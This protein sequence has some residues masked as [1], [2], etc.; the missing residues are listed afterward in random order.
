MT[1]LDELLERIHPK[2]T[3]E[4]TSARADQALNAFPIDSP[5]IK[6]WAEFEAFMACFFCHVESAILHI[7]PARQMD[8]D[9]D[10]A[11]CAKFLEKQYGKEGRK[12]AFEMARTG[13]EGGLYAVLKKVALKIAEEYSENEIRARVHQFLAELSPDE[14]NA[15]AK[16]YIQKF[17]HLLPSE[18]TEGSAARILASFSKYLE[19]HP[20]LIYKLRRIG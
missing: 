15:A 17:G 5:V 12:A 11:R 9:F 14:E 2:H 7:K 4:E 1:K 13:N 6:D 16:E 18:L 20:R 8:L 3:I 10:L 19:Q